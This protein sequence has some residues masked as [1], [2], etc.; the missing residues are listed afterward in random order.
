[1]FIIPPK[2]SKKF[3]QPNLGNFGGNLFSSFNLDVSSK[4]GVI[5]NMRSARIFDGLEFEPTVGDIDPVM[6]FALYDFTGN[7]QLE[8]IAWMGHIFY[9]GDP[10]SSIWN[11]DIFTGTPTYSSLEVGNGDMKVFNG[12]LY[13]TNES[14]LFEYFSSSWSNLAS[15]GGG[16][17]AMDNYG[18]RLYIVADNSQKIYSLDTTGVL[19]TSGSFTLDL[20][21]L[22]GFISWIKAGSNRI[23]LGLNFNNGNRGLIFEWD[24]QSE[25]TWNK[26]YVLEASGSCGATIWNDVP[27]V[28]DTEGRLLTY[29]GYNFQEVARLPIILNEQISDRSKLNEGNKLI[30]FNGILFINDRII[31][32]LDNDLYSLKKFNGFLNRKS[33]RIPS[34]I[35]EYT[36]ENGLIHLVCSSMNDYG[37]TE[38]IDYGQMYSSLPGAVFDISNLEGSPSQLRSD[39]IFG[40]RSLYKDNSSS[41]GIFANYQE[42]S[43]KKTGFLITQWLESNQIIEVWQSIVL[44]YKQILDNS[45]KIFVKYRTQDT[46]PFWV[47]DSITW[48]SPN[49]FFLPDNNTFQYAEVGDEV[50]II[51]R[52]GA[53]ESA[54][55][56]N[57]DLNSNVYTVLLD[58][59]IKGI[60]TGD[61]SSIVIE[62]WKKLTEFTGEE[63]HKNIPI[64]D[65]NKD[66][67]FQVKIIIEWS[68]DNELY[69]ILII[70]N[71]DQYAK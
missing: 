68:G 17:H 58:K 42:Q 50:V 16:I 51:E 44:K 25:N 21:F 62:K 6:A 41:W 9:S 66:I 36:K 22:D 56:I 23:W 67:H 5:R 29:N 35:W 55:I 14:D 61:T 4:N 8:V 13:V 39:F 30:H 32:N 20:S 28:L 49:E 48:N 15:L 24:G 45:V 12:K 11:V 54:H 63:Q 1:M 33:T 70:N 3:L 53:G 18:D 38:E 31:L 10:L 40:S 69:E 26:N 60:Q 7:G 19:A 37:D 46:E 65:L 34:G 43:L 59:N 2:D 57:I 27:Y 64:P 71:T 47:Q 52:S